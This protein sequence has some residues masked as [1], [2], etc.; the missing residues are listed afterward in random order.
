MQKQD[1]ETLFLSCLTLGELEKGVAKMAH[2]KRKTLLSGWI[3]HDLP[4]RF[5]GRILTIDANIARRWGRACAES[6]GAWRKRPVITSL[7]AITAI[8]HGLTVVTRNES[9]MKDTGVKIFNPWVSN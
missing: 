3:N 5:Q 8:E 6:E 4:V 7:I 9:D 1:E 2:S